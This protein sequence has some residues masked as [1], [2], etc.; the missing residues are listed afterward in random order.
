VEAPPLAVREPFTHVV[1]HKLERKN[2]RENTHERDRSTRMKQ[3]QVEEDV[4]V[5]TIPR[6]RRKT[7]SK[8]L[9]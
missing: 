1:V 6:R 8:A 2:R 3:P 9:P 4:E 7:P 5:A